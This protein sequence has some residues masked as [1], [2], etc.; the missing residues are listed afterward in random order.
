[1]NSKK[2]NQIL[3]NLTDEALYKAWCEGNLNA[4]NV[5]LE[6]YQSLLLLMAYKYCNNREIAKDISQNVWIEICK[7]AKFNYEIKSFKAY[8]Y[9]VCRNKYFDLFRKNKNSKEVTSSPTELPDE[10]I[11]SLEKQIEEKEAVQL[12]QQFI[13]SLPPLQKECYVLYV[14]E[15]MSMEEIATQLGITTNQVRGRI[16]RAKKRM[17]NIKKKIL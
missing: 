5:L 10:Q 1:M 13:L 4:A 11:F 7:K 17:K 15:E 2:Q 6:R 16:D 8:L 3:T 12:S 14:L 9:T